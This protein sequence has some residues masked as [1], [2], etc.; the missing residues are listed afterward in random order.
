MVV[1][2]ATQ[3]SNRGKSGVICR[4]KRP[5][6]DLRGGLTAAGSARFKEKEAANLKPGVTKSER[7]MAPDE[8]R[9]KGSLGPG[10]VT[11]V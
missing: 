4:K 2:G 1:G 11:H 10:A 7:E 6:K 9:R 5:L 8:M 3:K